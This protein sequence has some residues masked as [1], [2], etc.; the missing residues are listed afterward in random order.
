MEPPDAG[1]RF[2]SRSGAGEPG[3]AVRRPAP[4]R[5]W[6]PGGSRALWETCYHF[7][8]ITYFCLAPSMCHGRPETPL[9]TGKLGSGGFSK[10]SPTRENGGDSVSSDRLAAFPALHTG[11]MSRGPGR[12]MRGIVDTLGTYGRASTGELCSA[13]YGAE[14]EAASVSVR[15]ALRTLAA[16]GE[17][18]CLGFN[19]YGERVYCFPAERE[20]YLAPWASGGSSEAFGREFLKHHRA[21]F[22]RLWNSSRLPF[23]PEQ[24]E[25]RKRNA[26]AGRRMF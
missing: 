12:I 11:S 17:V 8:K 23:T 10:C 13:L 15:R 14:T 3:S 1:G 7:R 24:I 25:A 22:I 20:R 5:K 19:T 9:H 18:L 2:L 16:R 6:R 21:G 4:R 26:E